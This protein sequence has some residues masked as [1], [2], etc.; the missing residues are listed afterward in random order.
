MVYCTTQQV[1]DYLQLTQQVPDFDNGST[2][3]ETVDAS[4]TL[5]SGSK[6]YL[7]N[8]KIIDS[9]YNFYYGAD[10]DNITLLTETTH[11]TFD[12]DIG[13]ITLTTAG[14]TAIGA[15]S[16]FSDYKF[17]LQ[18]K[19][20]YVQDL[21]NSS[22]K[23][24]DETIEQTFNGVTLVDNEERVGKGIHKRLYRPRNLM[25]IVIQNQLDG[26]L[27]DST[28]TV[29]L[30][31]TTG[32]EVGEYLTIESEVV[33]IGS[34]DSSTNLTV[35]R[36]SK[37]STAVT[38]ADNTFVI[39][40]VISISNTVV[41]STPVFAI[42]NYKTEF[43]IDSD[44]GGVQLLHIDGYDANQFTNGLY[45]LHGVFNRIRINYK[46]GSVTVPEDI[47]H[48]CLLMTSKKLYSAQILNALSRG[49]DGFESGGI[50][51]ID[52]EIKN[53]LSKR[54]LLLSSAW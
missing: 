46:Y 27:D 19:D 53:I 11:Y 2:T 29:I 10:V 36:G 15:N 50:S 37:G 14:A 20:S 28:T 51:T 23:I 6:I 13:E 8:T 54:R 41:G 49:T 24:I 26:A 32:L 25:P 44:T 31:D 42:L 16:V 30:D 48:L 1:I 9:S 47:R 7:N 3:K 39:N 38:H 43:D 34:I 5:A 45:P 35:T 40:Y 33:L 17:S 4:G 22:E 12:K 52:D 21:I 18:L